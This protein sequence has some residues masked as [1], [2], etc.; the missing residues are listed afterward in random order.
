M[1]KNSISISIFE[2]LFELSNEALLI[3]DKECNII[4][5]N[6]FSENIFEIPVDTIKS[7]KV[8]ELFFKFVNPNNKDYL[9][10]NF[11]ENLYKNLYNTTQ[12]N[13]KPATSEYTLFFGDNKTKNIYVIYY[14]IIEQE[15][16]FIGVVIKED[17]SNILLRLNLEYRK[18]F[19]K[20]LSEI[21]QDFTS[22]ET[23]E[24]ED[25][26]LN[27]LKKFCLFANADGIVIYSVNDEIVVP[28]HAYFANTLQINVRKFKERVDNIHQ[29]IYSFF[30]NSDCISDNFLVDF[31]RTSPEVRK[32]MK[33]LGLA[34]I[35]IVPVVYDN[36][37]YG[38]IAIF[39]AM[40]DSSWRNEDSALLRTFTNILVS[41]IDRVNKEIQLQK[42]LT[43]NNNVALLS[44]YVINETELHKICQLVLYSFTNIFANHFS[45]LT[46]KN[47]GDQINVVHNPSFELDHNTISIL[48]NIIQEQ[49]A[50]DNFVF[51][52]FNRPFQ[53]KFNDYILTIENYL[54][55]PVEI[56][57]KNFG[58]IFLAN[59][60]SKFHKKDIKILSRILNVL[61]IALNRHIIQTKFI[62]SEKKYY[63]LLENAND[64]MFIMKD[65]KFY[66]VNQKFCEFT[67]YT[68][69]EIL[70]PAFDYFELIE[71]SSRPVIR[72]RALEMQEGKNL[73]TSFE[74]SV[75]R[76]DGEVRN[77]LLNEIHL[78]EPC[79]FHYFIGIVEDLTTT[80]RLHKIISRK[81]EILE[82][83]S[84]AAEQ[85]L[86]EPNWRK[87][88]KVSLDRLLSI[89]DSSVVYLFENISESEGTFILKCLNYSS[90]I[91]ISNE[92]LCTSPEF[93][94]LFSEDHNI[95]NKLLAGDIV[96]IH[97]D[98]LPPNHQKFP[99]NFHFTSLTFIP[100][101]PYNKFW[102][103]FL[104]RNVETK[105]QWIQQEIDAL[106]VAARIFA[107]AIINEQNEKAL[108]SM[109][110]ELEE[111]VRLRTA[112]LEDAL[113]ELRNA[114][115][116]LQ[117]A[118]LKEKEFS[119]L[120]ARFL[121]MI[122]EEY[123]SPLTV[124]LTSLF[125]MELAIVKNDLGTLS[126]HV[127]KIRIAAR[128]MTHLLDNVLV[129]GHLS[130]EEVLNEIHFSPF[131][132]ADLIENV[133]DEIKAIDQYHHN[134]N[135]SVDL[136]NKMIV[137]EENLFKTIMMNLVTNAV[138]YSPMNTDVHISV[139]L[140]ED[141]VIYVQVKD[142]GF[143]IPENDKKH[144]FEQ[145]YR[146][147]NSESIQGTGL[148]LYIVKNA[149]E[150]LG[151]EISFQSELGV[152]TSF[153]FSLP[154]HFIHT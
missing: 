142:Q 99:E 54:Y 49:F 77:V 101:I 148:G 4:Y 89:T 88:I 35:F 86:I 2:Q 97:N 122:S 115:D 146:G 50:K 74:L 110:V 25:K 137:T 23:Y 81:D 12:A 73:P 111:R 129:T 139:G 140:I 79:E 72:K 145:F 18:N 76:K 87:K 80:K 106:E 147:E 43:I 127:D 150:K 30:K 126:K 133:V 5:C 124:M 71:E 113:E 46:I 75:R 53:I 85:F 83:I 152:G 41:A 128:Q 24:L 91:D 131:N 105:Q 104:I 42:E 70:S 61:S 98:E 66:Y 64:S 114:K 21:A 138:Q 125:L 37:L 136:Q 67:G 102:G 69:D 22:L 3:V 20:L 151:G 107:A 100:I 135:I 134:F 55:A 63:S 118:Y 121:K 58:Y 95:K 9:T 15:N 1:N 68:K 28:E 141:N 144:I 143:G 56:E 120:R 6:S 29:W 7:F 84:H 109:N 82:T 59:K 40:L 13:E 31:E 57:G 45:F 92:Q 38:G 130:E 96:V 149:V 33:L 90:L 44:N 112:E 153:T 17:K 117:S 11:I 62:E 60:D 10:E 93:N 26:T 16:Q 27:A 51:E 48:D 52:N 8:N 94:L 19:E 32:Y 119:E 39:N 116:E 123:R 78:N 132:I 34:N 47:L 36:N 103:F 108:K 14:P 65:H 154:V